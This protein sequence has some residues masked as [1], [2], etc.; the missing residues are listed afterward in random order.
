MIQNCTAELGL[1]MY[2]A[3]GLRKTV[4]GVY[5]RLRVVSSSMGVYGEIKGLRRI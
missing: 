2:C 3:S 5:G 4:Y 1:R